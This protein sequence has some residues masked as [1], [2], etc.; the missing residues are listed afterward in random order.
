MI[1]NHQ[2]YGQSIIYFFYILLVIKCMNINAIFIL[3]W[4]FIY[5]TNNYGFKVLTYIWILLL[6]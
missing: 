5:E 6:Q 4:E 3:K 1:F 2:V